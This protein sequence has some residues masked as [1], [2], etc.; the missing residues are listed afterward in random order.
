MNSLKH[1]SQGSSGNS[2][3]LKSGPEISKK[4]FGIRHLVFPIL[5][6]LGSILFWGFSSLFFTLADLRNLAYLFA[7]WLTVMVFLLLLCVLASNRRI[8]YSTLVISAGFF[9]LFFSTD[10]ENIFVSY[11]IGILVFLILLVIAV[12][13]MFKEKEQRLKI[14]L[15]KIWARGL[16]WIITALSLVV[17]LIY[18][19]NP[20]I[21]VGQEKIEIPTGFFNLILKPASGVISRMIPFYSP[22]MTLDQT[23][24]AALVLQGGEEISSQDIPAELLEKIRPKEDGL[25]VNALLQDQEIM[26]LIEQAGQGINDDILAE[27]REQLSESLGVEL[28]GNETMDVV[29]ADIVNTRI[30][31]FVGPNTRVISLAIAVALFFLLKLVGKLLGIVAVILSRMIFSLLR[32]FKIVKIREEMKPG[33]VIGF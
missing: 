4:D 13:L 31:S 30:N 19:F 32:L 1:L 29:L 7:G 23:L 33:E 16:P 9:F 12:A 14:S 11:L 8:V 10:G 22:E 27:Q 6:V 2:N 15:R 24:S 17:A 21:R 20:L 3:L 28:S 5:M 26:S 25:D 18:Y